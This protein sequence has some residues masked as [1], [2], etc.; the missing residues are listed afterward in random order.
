MHP[1][2]YGTGANN[3]PQGVD[4]EWVSIFPEWVNVKNIDFYPY[5]EKDFRYAWKESG[6]SIT[7]NPYVRIRMTLGL[8]WEKRKTIKGPPADMT[9]T[10]TV[11]LSR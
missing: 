10:T 3:L 6:E 1:D 2:Y 4:T 11:N 7:L 8:A 5:P 9:I